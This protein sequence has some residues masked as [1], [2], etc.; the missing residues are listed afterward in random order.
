[1]LIE[2]DKCECCAVHDPLIGH[3]KLSDLLVV[4][5]CSCP[6]RNLATPVLSWGRV[7]RQ[8]SQANGFHKT[9]TIWPLGWG[10]TF[11]NECPEKYLR[12]T[13]LKQTESNFKNNTQNQCALF[14]Y[15]STRIH[16]FQIGDIEQ[17]N[18]I[19]KH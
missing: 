15:T 5:N 10:A 12:N 3:H 19:I 16:E 7:L 9:T 8:E 2:L 1:M 17:S 14:Y 13:N 18:S 4:A 6:T 11:R